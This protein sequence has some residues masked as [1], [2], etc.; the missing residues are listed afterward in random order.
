MA[1]Q[2]YSTSLL[3]PMYIKT[4]SDLRSR[5]VE[6]APPHTYYQAIPERLGVHMI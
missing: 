6:F 1:V 2:E 5:G 3:Q 4:V